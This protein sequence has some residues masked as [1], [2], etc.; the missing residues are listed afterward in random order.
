MRRAHKACLW[1]LVTLAGGATRSVA[2]PARSDN[3]DLPAT[4]RQ[5]LHPGR[6]G[7][8]RCRDGPVTGPGARA[9]CRGQRGAAPSPPPAR[10]LRLPRSGGGQAT[11]GPPPGQ[12]AHVRLGGV[13]RRDGLATRH[14]PT[15]APAVGAA[16]SGP[17]VGGL[18]ADASVGWR[19]GRVRRRRLCQHE[20]RLGRQLGTT[21]SRSRGTRSA[22][23]RTRCFRSATAGGSSFAAG[24][25]RRPPSASLRATPT[26]DSRG[27]WAALARAAFTSSRAWPMVTWPSSSPSA[28]A[29][30]AIRRT[31]P[32]SAP[33]A[34]A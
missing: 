13:P 19:R 1:A 34:A 31:A 11:L 4:L 27:R 28:T 3:D 8:A 15:G 20:V 10:D 21:V 24:S 9:G 29:R 12:R 33:T 25:S 14:L 17:R 16:D 18:D 7:R 22:S 30:R 2:A 6:G 23:G 26:P 32:R 5:R